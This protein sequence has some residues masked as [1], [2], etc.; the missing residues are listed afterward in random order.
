[1]DF[2]SKIYG[3]VFGFDGEIRDLFLAFTGCMVSVRSTMQNITATA[4][5]NANR[6]FAGL[7]RFFA[8]APQAYAF[9]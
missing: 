7:G 9:A 5:Y 2:L 6:L 8:P 1:M 4:R 3:G